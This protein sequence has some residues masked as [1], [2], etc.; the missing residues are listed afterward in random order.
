MKT[1][2]LLFSFALLTITAQAQ[3][4]LSSF[5][6]KYSGKEGFTSVNVSPDLFQLLANVQ[7]NEDIDEMK[8]A[9]KGLKGIQV[10]AF[11]K[12]DLM[13]DGRELYRE[14]FAQINSRDYKELVSVQDGSENVRIMARDLGNGTM[15]QLLILV[16]SPDEFVFVNIDGI[17]DLNAM[18]KLSEG[19]DIEGLDQLQ[20]LEQK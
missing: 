6:S 9:I 13:L 11:E 5:F 18:M 15:E 4:P 3:Q 2:I 10:L 19:M 12:G 1:L 7:G 17:I 8:E 20:N 16:G 14:A